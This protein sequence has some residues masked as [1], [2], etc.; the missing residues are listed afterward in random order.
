MRNLWLGLVVVG[1]S[2]C[3]TSAVNFE[4][5]SELAVASRGIAL[6][7]DGVDGVVGMFGTTCRVM[8]HD[9]TI[10]EDYNFP[11][12]DE[13]VV[14]AT[15]LF[16][17]NAV[18]VISDMGAHVTYPDR[19]WDWGTD[20]FGGPG[21]LEGSIYDDGVAMLADNPCRVDWSNGTD[22]VTTE[23]PDDLCQG[24][25][26][27]ADRS[28]GRVFVANGDVVKVTEDGYENIAE[29]ADLVV[30][31]MAAQVLYATLTGSSTLQ[32]IEEDGAI[33]W[34]TEVEGSIVTLDVMGMLGQ[35]AVMVEKANGAGALLTVDGYTGEI[36]SSL[37]TPSAAEQVESSDNGK[38]LAVVL[39]RE[40]H[41]FNVR[42]AP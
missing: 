10:G 16:G 38:T 12:E 18:L 31:D 28:D 40:V 24:A 15:E 6:N 17:D 3:T 41:F 35:A 1:A 2:A 7:T 34:T 22:A 9:G 27:T 42:S 37:A 14:D 4:H 20:D 5:Q 26:F 8:V 30:W 32:G 13:R 29:G 23:V 39:P 11:T 21:V 19:V 25:S 33:R 36:T